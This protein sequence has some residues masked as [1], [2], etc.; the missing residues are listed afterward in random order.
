MPAKPAAE[1]AV[2]TET[3]ITKIIEQAQPKVPDPPAAP[4]IARQKVE[5][6]Y[7]EVVAHAKDSVCRDFYR[8]KEY[9]RRVAEMQKGDDGGITTAAVS[10]A[11]IRAQHRRLKMEDT[12][13]WWTPRIQQFSFF[14]LSASLGMGACLSVYFTFKFN[15]M[16]FIMLPALSVG[17]YKSWLEFETISEEIRYMANQQALRERREKAKESVKA[18]VEGASATTIAASS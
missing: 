9:K 16:F 15:Q 3:D 12:T 6:T 11:N 13:S 17:S 2:S 8:V 18:E 10:N 7:E 14:G 4:R 1:A 5:L